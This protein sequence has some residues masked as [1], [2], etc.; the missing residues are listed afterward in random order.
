MLNKEQFKLTQKEVKFLDREREKKLHTKPGDE[1]NISEM[2]R[3]FKTMSLYINCFIYMK[4]ARFLLISS[5][6]KSRY[7]IDVCTVMMADS[8]GW[9]FSGKKKKKTIL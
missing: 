8:L 1:G 7:F 2:H 9:F 6:N 5:S 3:F 4:L